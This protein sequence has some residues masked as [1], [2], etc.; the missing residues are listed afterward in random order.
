VEA[1]GERERAV[2]P[3]L[4]SLLAAALGFLLLAIVLALLLFHRQ[5]FV[6]P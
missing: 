2:A 6:V 4:R 5:R 3:L 1:V